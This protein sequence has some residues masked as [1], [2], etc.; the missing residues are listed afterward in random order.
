[1]DL[2]PA[3]QGQHH[4][5]ALTVGKVDHVLIDEHSVG[6]QGETEVLARLLLNGPGIGNQLL[7]HIKVHQGLAAE[8]VHLQVFPGAGMG[9]QEVK[10]LLAHLKGHQR[11]VSVVLALGGKAVGAV[12]VAGVGDV[13]AQGLHH[14]G[15]PGLQLSGHGRKGV[16]SKE[17]PRVLQ[18]GDVLVARLQFFPVKLRVFPGHLVDGRFPGRVFVE[19]NQVVSRLIHHMDGAGAHIQNDVVAV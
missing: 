7:Y 3:V 13:Q 1:M 15:G 2:L 8:E 10:G 6:G 4:V 14:S 9:N 12:Q 19:A 18:G 17:L 16:R 5:A 11:P